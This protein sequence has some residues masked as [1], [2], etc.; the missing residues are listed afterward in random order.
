MARR[1]C[2]EVPNV[3][4]KAE[5]KVLAANNKNGLASIRRSLLTVIVP[6][7]FIVRN[8]FLLKGVAA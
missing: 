4:E 6:T 3:L 2:R 7:L 8:Y 1:F 5:K